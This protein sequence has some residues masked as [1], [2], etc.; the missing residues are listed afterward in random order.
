[1]LTRQWLRFGDAQIDVVNDFT[2]LTLDTIAFCTFSHRFNSFY[3]EEP[4]AFVNAMASSLKMSGLRSRR[5]PAPAFVYSN[6]NK[7]YEEEIKVQ[8]DIADGVSRR[9]D[10]SNGPLTT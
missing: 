7:Q 6:A 1:M 2:K 10:S 9:S 4:P 5:L 3:S 8:H